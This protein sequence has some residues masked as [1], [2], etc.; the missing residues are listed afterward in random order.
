[1][2]SG[3]SAV[4]PQNY[5]PISLLNSIGKLLEKCIYSRLVEIVETKNLLPKFQFGFRRGHSTTHQGKRLH[6]YIVRNKSIRKSTGV[7]LLDI[8]KAFDSIWHD[9][10]IHKLIK[11][12]L[13]TYLVRLINAF[14]RNRQ[15]A[16]HV[17]NNISLKMDIPAGLAQG[18]CISPIL[19][20]LY[21]ADIP[22]SKKT[23]LAL[24]ADDTA[25]YTAAKKSNTIV[26]RLNSSMD[27]LR[28]YFTKW[29]IK[30]N[31]SKTQAIIFPFNNSKKRNPTAVLKSQRDTIK[32]SKQVNYLGIHFDRKLTFMQHIT[33]SLIKANR[34]Y[35]A[36]YTML[37]RKSRLSTSN[38]HLIYT[39]V[40]RPI[41]AYAAPV[42]A[43]AACSHI[44]KMNI[45]QNKIVKTIYDLPFRTPTYMLQG[46]TNIQPFDDYIRSLSTDF[47]RNCAISDYELI[48]EIEQ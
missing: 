13:P 22:V 7:V 3:K 10:L 40:I 1:M 48:R 5:R 19:Y 45:L 42:W 25:I 43:T 36:L 9:G 31:S 18:T 21:V 24:F 12:K 34:C 2:K 30:I 8:E 26:N 35:R 4:D 44:R 14:I 38:K 41:L 27:D 32:W 15:Y 46:L 39:S 23:N 17:N 33:A 16:V 37:A 20:A 6:K 11:M 47:L 29:R 28:D